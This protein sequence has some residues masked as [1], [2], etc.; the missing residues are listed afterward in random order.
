MRLLNVLK[1]TV[2]ENYSDNL[3]S[4]VSN[5]VKQLLLSKWSGTTEDTPEIIISNID[6]FDSIKSGLPVDRRD[7]MR[8]SYNELKNVIRDKK[9]SKNF[10]DII[11]Q[12][13]KREKGI[14]NNLLKKYV[15]RFLEIQSEL[16][17]NLNDISK[18]SYLK[19]KKLIDGSYD[20]LITKKLL[21]NFT[22]E[23]GFTK[24]QILFYITNYLGILDEIPANTKPV[25]SMNMTEFE[26]LVDGILATK[27]GIDVPKTKD[28]SDID[29][30]YNE[31]NL[32]IYAPKTKD[33]CIRL[34]FGRSWCTSREGSGNYYYNYRLNHMLTLYYVVDEDR[35]YEDLDYAD[36]I[37]V[38]RDG[39]MRLADKSNS[40]R[41][42]GHQTLPWDEIVEKMPK[43]EG[44]KHLLKPNP[45]TPTELE[46][47]QKVRGVRVG[48]NPMETF[49][50]EEE[51]AL[52]LE[53]NDS[54]ITD[55]QYANI[56]PSLK[57]K[58]IGMGYQLTPNMIESSESEV[59]KYY[60]NKRQESIVQSNI[61][62]L[63][64]SD[65]SLLNSPLLKKVKDGLKKKFAKELTI[66]GSTTFRVTDIY[67]GDVGKFIS[68][69]GIEDLIESLPDNLLKFEIHNV[70]SNPINFT[71]P[72]SITKFKDLELLLFRNCIT[73][74]PDYVCQLN[75]LEFLSV[76]NTPNL[77]KIPECIANLPNLSFI[78]FE[79]SNYL[80]ILP[81]SIKEKI[82]SDDSGFITL[83]A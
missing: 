37:L 53:M 65:I 60:I 25:D 8:Y 24:E 29:L 15:K 46:N 67:K 17:E 1:T 49:K 33:Q 42:S 51:V 50:D 4:E 32:K 20:K 47:I 48:N 34:S 82:E 55:E 43:L 74:I 69:Y 45:L 16:P 22:K 83:K 19:L 39:R 11:T 38:E 54:R 12:F 80:D 31:N 56:T 41:Y 40:G 59:L 66:D 68:L 75:N 7:I 63:S 81:D 26:H 64:E 57:K 61:S 36:V 6:E 5:K 77:T 62:K 9:T 52:W 44:L 18:Y 76:I 78:N 13:V 2:R 35:D 58:Y 73:E 10:N 71:I 3:I 30:I 28:L 21:D 70:S 23:G 14:D 79:N 72:S 27:G